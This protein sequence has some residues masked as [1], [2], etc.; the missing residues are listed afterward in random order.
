MMSSLFGIMT[1]EGVVE[2]SDVVI[3]LLAVGL[4]YS[5]RHGVIRRDFFKGLMIILGFSTILFRLSDLS[6]SNDELDESELDDD[7]DEDDKHDVAMTLD[8]FTFE[9]ELN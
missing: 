6:Y 8:E 2:A 4:Q 5:S 9:R 1:I 7:E 3:M